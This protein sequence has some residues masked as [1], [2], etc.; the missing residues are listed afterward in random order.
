MVQHRPFYGWKLLAAL[1]AIASVNQGVT[2]LGAAVI[3]APMA[4]DLGI[5]RGTLGLGSTVF[6]LCIALTAPLAARMVNSFG[7]RTTLCT[8]SSLVA[9]GSILLATCASRGWH[10]VVG[11]GFLLG[12]GCS[13]G[14]MVPAQSC[15]T[16]WFEKR[17]AMALSLVLVGAGVGGSISAPLL[18]SV[19]GAHGNW[20][21]GWFSVFAVALAAAL[22]SILF[23]KNRPEELEQVADGPAKAVGKISGDI[24][25]QPSRVYRTRDHWTLREAVHT[26]AFWLLTLASIGE[27]VP[28]TAA[29]A[30]AVPHLRDLGHTAAA[31]GSA[32]GIFSVCSIVGSLMI[33]FLCD[34]M[35]PR[36]AWAICI[37][38]IGSGVF[39]ATR[40]GSD[41]AMYLFTGMI[42]FGSGAA[43]ASWHATVANYFGPA[44]FP[45]I[46]GAQMPVST[47]LAAA[48]PFLVGMVYD[49]RGSYTPA[50]LALGAFSVLTAIL[51]FF[52]N[53]PARSSLTVSR[54]RAAAL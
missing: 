19:I 9:L 31:A 29:I 33:G 17:R 5:S 24:A 42:G 20:R 25:S 4:K 6:V 10:F 7:A 46:L 34:R 21:A 35:D 51:L 15:A 27:S 41:V 39:I 40:A 23:V 3:N 13:F 47:T 37:L 32:I 16:L 44:S 12:A 54:A 8:G 52:T 11:Y 49:M 48:S 43:L 53:P 2:Y 22:V 18:T 26:P 45:S 36:I 38:M 50:F 14:S 30:H 1:A 28:G